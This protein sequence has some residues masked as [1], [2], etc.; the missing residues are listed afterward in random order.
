MT[1]LPTSKLITSTSSKKRSRLFKKTRPVVRKYVAEDLPFLWAA[2]GQGS[3]NL[4][5][6]LTQEAFAGAM[7][8]QFGSFDL[9]W[10]IEDETPAFKAG[11]GQ[12][13]IVGIKS[14]GWSYEPVAVFFKWAKPKT[15]LRALV[16]FF[17]MIRYQKDV[18][19]C[20]VTATQ[21]DSKML[22]R[23]KQYGVLFY[24]GR[25]PFGSAVGDEFIYSIQ[26]GR[27]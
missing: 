23:L 7:A 14:D 6:G 16:S 18:G 20:K 3:F 26:G 17:Q 22:Q 1:H 24:R 21:K 19:V 27:K 25:I 11:R 15:V 8:A 12:V 13:A 2:Y 9:L 10:V 5:A 4:P